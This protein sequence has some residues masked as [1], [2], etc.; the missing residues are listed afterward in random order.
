M[1]KLLIVLLL[2][3]PVAAAGD[4]S[5][6]EREDWRQHFESAAVR[7]TIVVHDARR[8]E[9]F[10]FDTA[11]AAVR[12]MPASTFKIPHALIAL[13]AGVVRDEFQVFPWDGRHHAIASWNRDQDLRRSMRNST[14]WLYQQF[15]RDIGEAREREWL[16]RLDYGNAEIGSSVEE[17]WLDGSLRISAIEQIAF[18]ER[19]YRN[20]LPFALA[21][22]RLVKDIMIVE[23]G[24]DW[25]LR[26]KT[27]WGIRVQPEIGWWVGWVEH[28]EGPV[29]F[30]LNIDLPRD[31]VADM[32][33]R[34]SVA[35][36]VLK[37]LG[38]L[39]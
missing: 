29:Y 34:E 6:I 3:S 11:R 25:I 37:D 1:H 20:E 7:G 28:P 16:A 19:L 24:R 17:F 35:R 26:A 31:R 2:S 39:H 10:A 38:A 12:F 30:A 15:A 33:K 21:H 4:A 32:G 36:A 27:G 22:Q 23:A 18:L 8:G 9:R 14:V 13:E 5:W